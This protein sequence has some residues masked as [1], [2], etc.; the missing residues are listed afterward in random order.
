MMTVGGLR[1]EWGGRRL[2]TELGVSNAH[3][4]NRKE[5]AKTAGD[6]TYS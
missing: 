2:E 1:K 3:V 5:A 6:G 4:T